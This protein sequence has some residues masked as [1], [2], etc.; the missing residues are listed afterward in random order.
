LI[1]GLIVVVA[2]IVAGAGVYYAAL[3]GVEDAE[4]RIH[5]RLRTHAGVETGKLPRRI[6]GA[7]VA[8]E[9]RRFYDHGA[10][11]VRALLRALETGLTQQGVDPGGSTIT[12]QLAKLLYPTAGGIGGGFHDVAI[13]TKLERRYSKTE[14]L[15]MYLT[16]VYLGD[17]QYGVRKAATGYYGRRA[18]QLSWAQASLL[19]GLLQ[20]PTAYEPRGHF[21]RARQRQREVVAALLATRRLSTRQARRIA[22]RPRMS[23]PIRRRR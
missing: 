10:L 4:A 11:D 12:Q 5:R 9:D 1:V 8:V 2:L 18:E 17:G 7:V 20:A 23:L 19:A 22:D 14:I 6:A 21:A 13:A 3:P 15:E 16:A